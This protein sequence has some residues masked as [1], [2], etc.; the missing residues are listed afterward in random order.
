MAQS[1]QRQETTTIGYHEGIRIPSRRILCVRHFRA[2]RAH[3]LIGSDSS[4]MSI[5]GVRR[6][7]YVVFAATRDSTSLPETLGVRP[8][9]R[10]L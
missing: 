5:W 9:L 10:L 1:P 2:N 6:Q 4:S 7:G 8:A 3:S